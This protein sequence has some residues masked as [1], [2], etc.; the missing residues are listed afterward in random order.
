M[1]DLNRYL[2]TLTDLDFSEKG[3][4]RIVITATDEEEAFQIADVY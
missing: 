1:Y 4:S 2:L 3:T